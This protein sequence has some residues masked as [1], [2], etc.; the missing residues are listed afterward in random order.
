MWAYILNMMNVAI[1]LAGGSGSRLGGEL[2]KQFLKVAGKKI[3]EHTIDVF[4]SHDLIDEVAVVCR[5]D[6]MDTL[7]E[8][9]AANRY[10]KVR[11]ILPG[12]KERYDSSLAAINAYQDDDINLLLH[13]AVRPLVNHRIIDDCLKALQQY[14]AVDV[15]ATTT[16]TI[17]QVDAN[18]C[19]KAIPPRQW[20]R[21]G[22]TPQCF[23][24]GVIRKAY[25]IA[26]K[27]P[28]FVTTDDCGVVR[29]YLPDEPIYV[30][31]GEMFNMK[32]T[33][34]EDLFLLDKLYQLKSVAGNQQP[35]E[36]TAS[37]LKE[38]VIVVFG[39]SSGIGKEIV[40]Y[41]NQL[42]AKA[43]AYSRRE[44][45]VDVANPEK[46]AAAL[47]EVEKKEGRIDYVV[48]TPGGLIKEPIMSMDYKE[49]AAIVKTNYLGAVV[50]AKESYPYLRKTAGGLVFF[51]SSTYSRGRM[52][53]SIYS[54]TKAALV[55]LTQALSEEWS[56]DNVRVNCINPDATR[57]A[58]RI[59]HFG[60]EPDGHLLEP[61][62]VA[63]SV[64]NA[65]VSVYNGQVIDVKR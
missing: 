6:Y 31:D 48:C 25:D 17:V 55:N 10:R 5:P 34:S 54:S 40:T 57:T 3:I 14:R 16:D 18:D 32:V 36:K 29:R 46:V 7:K 62:Q 2:P 37:L 64:L 1:I 27:D 19:I 15:A 39:G 42:G 41:A 52:L 20:L 49:I 24:R 4:D 63:W 35:Q 9:L 53:Y 38:K 13:D 11:K 51:T 43:Y 65:L 21:N 26:L 30:V 45:N 33:Y 60:L 28:N 59:R 50:V 22:Q 61:D 12:G 47:Q 8:I 44:G 58:F 56:D 23:K